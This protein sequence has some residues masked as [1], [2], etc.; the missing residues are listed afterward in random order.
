MA[1]SFSFLFKLFFF[2]FQS[3]QNLVKNK[4]KEKLLFGESRHRHCGIRTVDPHPHPTP[5]ATPLAPLPTFPY[6]S[7]CVLR[8]LLP[9]GHFVLQFLHL[10]LRSAGLLLQR[11]LFRGGSVDV[12]VACLQQVLVLVQ[13]TLGTFDFILGTQV[14]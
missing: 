5:H 4:N 7:S 2:K 3:L 12:L 6:L 9:F 8:V 10:E 14:N 13:L 11:P 1:F